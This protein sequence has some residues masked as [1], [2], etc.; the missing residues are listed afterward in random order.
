MKFTPRDKRHA[1]SDK[2]R[3]TSL[4]RFTDP[5]Q[6][7]SYV[8]AQFRAKG[9]RVVVKSPNDPKP[10]STT[11]LPGLL[12]LAHDWGSKSLGA[13]AVVLAHERI[14]LMQMC[15]VGPGRFV[16]RY[17]LKPRE[18]WIWEMQGYVESLRTSLRLGHSIEGHAERIARQ[19][20]S[21]YKPWFRFRLSEVRQ[22]SLAMLSEIG[23]P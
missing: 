6:I 2:Y 20:A 23:S 4:E 15:D 3:S 9:F 18:R 8:L 12:W 7:C 21:D 14:H 5:R 22:A 10:D 17:A 1:R 19:M 13:Q 16:A 11:T